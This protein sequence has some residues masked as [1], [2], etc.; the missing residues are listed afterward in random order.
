MR[1][2]KAVAGLN[3]GLARALARCVDKLEAKRV[4]RKASKLEK[5]ALK[6]EQAASSREAPVGRNRGAAGKPERKSRSERRCC[7]GTKHQEDAKDYTESRKGLWPVGIANSNS[8]L[9][10][11]A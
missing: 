7:Y 11:P 10:P 6:K 4:I 3:G 9:Y 2:K 8:H 5:Y 1:S